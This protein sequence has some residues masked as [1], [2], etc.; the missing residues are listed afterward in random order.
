MNEDQYH[1]SC[2]VILLHMQFLP[3]KKLIR[4]QL[5]KCHCIVFKLVEHVKVEHGNF[6]L[7]NVIC[8]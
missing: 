6:R 7:K 4:V 8:A 1:A 2:L 3:Y 5:C